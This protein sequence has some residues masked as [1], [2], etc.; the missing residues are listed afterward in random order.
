MEI[1]I[2]KHSGNDFNKIKL[3]PFKFAVGRGMQDLAG[4]TSLL[5]K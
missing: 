3:R 1:V 4:L 2:L 5:E